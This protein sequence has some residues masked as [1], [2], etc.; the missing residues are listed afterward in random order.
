MQMRAFTDDYLDAE[1][2]LW[3]MAHTEPSDE[4]F[5]EAAEAFDALYFGPSLYS[6]ISRPRYLD[7]KRF[8]DFQALLAAKQKRP[9]FYVQEELGRGTAVLGSIDAGSTQRFELI[10][11][12]LLQGQPKITSSYLTNVDGTFGYSAGE[13]VGET[14][15][16]PG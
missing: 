7:T 14:L 12:R 13:A 8:A 9:L 4:R 5:F 6:D 10:R 15:P 11:I 16:D 3:V 2:A 1:Y